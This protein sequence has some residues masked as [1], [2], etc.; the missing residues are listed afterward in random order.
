MNKRPIVRASIEPLNG[1]MWVLPAAKLSDGYH[2]EPVLGSL[3]YG[4]RVAI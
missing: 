2:P 4:A 3:R 1:G